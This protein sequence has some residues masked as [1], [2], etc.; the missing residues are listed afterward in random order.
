MRRLP[1]A[2]ALAAYAAV[3]GFWAA[4]RVAPFALP[5][6]GA[7]LQG[8][9]TA[10]AAGALWA[11]AAT[12]L[13]FVPVGF[14]A[15]LIARRGGEGQ[16]G[17]G[18]RRGALA[19]GGS[20]VVVAIVFVLWPGRSW[21]VTDALSAALALAG[22]GAGVW[23][24]A[25]CTRGPRGLRGL[26]WKVPAAAAAAGAAAV[27]LLVLAVE[28]EPLPSPG[29]A[30]TSEE[31]RRVY[32]VVREA[33]PRTVPRGRTRTLRLS[34]RELDVLASWAQEIA[35]RNWR[36]AVDLGEGSVR[37]SSSLPVRAGG[38]RR[39][40]NAVVQ[41]RPTLDGGRLS[42]GLEELRAGRVRVPR[43]IVAVVSALAGAAL[44]HD[45]S[46]RPFVEATR[47]LK[48]E[49]AAVS[50]T[51]GR[52]NAPPGYVAGMLGR[53]LSGDLDVDAV[54]AHVRHLVQESQRIP[55]GDAAAGQALAAAF[56]FARQRS[57]ETSALL[58]NKA[59]LFALGILLGHSRLQ[60][61]VGRA[62]ESEDWRGLAPSLR[63]VRLQGRSD[64]TRHFFVSAALTVLSAESVS[65]AAGVFKEELDAD[66]GSGFSFGDLLADRAGTCLALAA[67]RDEAGARAMQERLAAGAAIEEFFPP[68]AD[69]PEKIT[70]AD[71]QRD[72]GG[73][74]GEA[75]RRLAADIESRLAWCEPYR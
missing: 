45:E 51:Y 64:W 71:L 3:L 41:A 48:V 31:K 72:Y 63:K 39:F 1:A 19:A 54:R 32:Y 70:D 7:V 14:L 16:V 68:A 37:A 6:P 33:N 69:L 35:G 49:P 62:V 10:A 75:Y 53:G 26:L 25:A 36:A 58:E 18:L 17:L 38:R 55:R 15:V 73:V 27:L 12:A 34:G 9:L 11:V 40:L 57:G 8:S 22:C 59:G 74:G 47:T 24:G 61:F 5:A 28:A 44:R 50:I 13:L 56:A 43:L 42:L 52:V 67:T 66:G 60:T 23:I 2:I 65:D 20:A 4:A 21:R 29:A 30:I 46:L